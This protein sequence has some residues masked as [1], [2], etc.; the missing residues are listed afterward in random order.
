MKKVESVDINILKPKQTLY[1]VDEPN[2]RSIE[3]IS[4]DLDKGLATIKSEGGFIYN[5]TTT[6]FYG[7]YKSEIDAYLKML[8]NIKERIKNTQNLKKTIEEK[9][10]EAREKTKKQKS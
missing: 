2:V 5:I 9:F 7:C 8:E 6:Y 10:K 1:L 3:I 4:I